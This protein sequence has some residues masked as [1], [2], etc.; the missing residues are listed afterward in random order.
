LWHCADARLT[1]ACPCGRREI[2][3]PGRIF[4]GQPLGARLHALVQ[5]LRCRSCG[6][7]PRAVDVRR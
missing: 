1:L 6:A 2:V 7:R 5:R 3:Q 4:A